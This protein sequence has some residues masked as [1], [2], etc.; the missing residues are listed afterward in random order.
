[1]KRLIAFVVLV[2]VLTSCSIIDNLFRR[3]KPAEPVKSEAPEEAKEQTK[4]KKWVNA[5]TE[6]DLYNTRRKNIA[7]KTARLRRVKRSTT[8]NHT[9]QKSDEPDPVAIEEP[10]EVVYILRIKSDSGQVVYQE[11]M[12]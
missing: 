12:K 7:Y 8:V 9:E 4:E 2:A 1:M 3:S 6:Q 10:R 5:F 11:K